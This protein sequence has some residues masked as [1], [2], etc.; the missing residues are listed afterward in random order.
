MTTGGKSTI[1]T[2]TRL[3]KRLGKHFSVR[4]QFRLNISFVSNATHGSRALYARKYPHR[5]IVT[6]SVKLGVIQHTDAAR[7]DLTMADV[8]ESGVNRVSSRRH[9]HTTPS[10]DRSATSLP[11]SELVSAIQ[12]AAV[13]IAS[14]LQQFSDRTERRRNR[15]KYVL[16]TTRQGT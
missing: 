11:F 4:Q 9:M 7:P 6:A 10:A 16:V 13:L 1:H 14:Q 3:Q 2:E 5:V 12:Q 15:N 8:S